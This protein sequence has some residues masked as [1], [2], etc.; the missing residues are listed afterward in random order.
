MRYIFKIVCHLKSSKTKQQRNSSSNIYGTTPAS[1]QPC[2]HDI[3]SI[4]GERLKVGTT[5]P[6]RYKA[7]ENYLTERP[8]RKNWGKEARISCLSLKGWQLRRAG[9]YKDCSMLPLLPVSSSAFQV[10]RRISLF[11]GGQWE[12]FLTYSTSLCSYTLPHPSSCFT[13]PTVLSEHPLFD[14]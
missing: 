11:P 10:H 9:A 4:L 5:R 1:Y 8:G 14:S 13:C 3:S 12:S 2:S 7:R 6:G